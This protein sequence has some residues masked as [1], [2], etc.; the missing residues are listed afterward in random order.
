MYLLL[1]NVIVVN[2]HEN[3]GILIL[4]D[5]SALKHDKR[6]YAVTFDWVSTPEGKQI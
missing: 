3:E 6:G 5:I 1:I 2:Y 4:I